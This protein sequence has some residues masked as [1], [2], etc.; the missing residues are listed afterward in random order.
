[1]YLLI[2]E[3]KENEVMVLTSFLEEYYQGNIDGLIQ[4]P[5]SSFPVLPTES[6]GRGKSYQLYYNKTDKTLSYKVISRSLTQEEK[7][8][9]QQEQIAQLLLTNALLSQD[10]ETLK[11]QNADILLKLAKN[12]IN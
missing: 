8:E 3:S 1:M 12:N 11:K 2:A 4:V 10:N 7:L 9:V 5:N 6:P